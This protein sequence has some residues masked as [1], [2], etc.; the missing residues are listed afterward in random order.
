MYI[1]GC[2]HAKSNHFR[3]VGF[4]ALVRII[5]RLFQKPVKT[6]ENGL[7]SRNTFEMY[8]VYTGHLSSVYNNKSEIVRINIT[9]I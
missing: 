3:A 5:A 4:S 9:K 7:I 1:L 6:P 8:Y 2:F